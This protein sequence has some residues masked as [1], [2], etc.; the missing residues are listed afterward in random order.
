MSSNI[1]V[2]KICEFCGNKFTAKTLFTR[3]CSKRCNSRHYK[4]VAQAEKAKILGTQVTT[5]ETSPVETLIYTDQDYFEL[6]EAAQI[7]RISKRTLYRL[8]ASRKLKKKKILTRTVILR[9]DIKM[10][11]AIQ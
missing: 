6:N 1:A 4:Q 10:F 8:L 5:T 11:F 2:Q 9:E 3:Y 7:M